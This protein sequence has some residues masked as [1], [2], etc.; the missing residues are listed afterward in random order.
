MSRILLVD[1][2]ASL[3]KLMSMRLRSQGYEVDTADSAEGALDRLRQQR[4]DLVL[5][6]LRMA[7]M[8]GLALFERIQS[9]WLG[10]PVI[11]MTAH[12]TIPDAIQ[13]TRSGVFSFLTKPIDK[14]EL[15]ATIEHALSLTRPKQRQEWQ[16]LILTRNPQMEQLLIQASS[17]ATMEVPVLIMGPSGSGKGVMTQALHQASSR[18]DQPLFVINCAALPWAALDLQLFGEDGQSGLFEQAKGATLFLDEIGDL[19]ESLQAKLLQVLQEYG[20]GTPEVRVISSS[21][22]DLVAAMEEGRFR[23]DL[24]YR[25]N[26]ANITMPP[27]SARSE[28]IPL[29]ARQ[30]LD[31]YRSRHGECAALGF[32]PEALALL[33][34]AW[35][36]N[37][38]QLYS[39]VEQLASLCCSPVIGAAMVESALSGGSGGIP[40]F[41]EARAEFEKEYLIRL[42]RTTEG[43]VTLAA[44]MAGRNRTDFYKLLNRHGI[45]AA[46]FKSKG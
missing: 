32:S 16:S 22:Q 34:A 5:S 45:E 46:N 40:S 10:L 42:L 6:D 23:E 20:Q 33:A 27:L 29:L 15:F 31:E 30:A 39:V 26:V 36:G 3:L 18:R 41:N 8:D 17:I 24:F 35:P 12:G 1:D 2:D 25:L 13:A 11:I 7:G 9:Q 37:V 38:R 43:N 21:H 28:D 44:S 4:A 19:S 14:D